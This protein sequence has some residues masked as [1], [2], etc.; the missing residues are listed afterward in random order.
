[1]SEATMP[2]LSPGTGAMP[3]VGG[4]PAI[5]TGDVIMPDNWTIPQS[6]MNDANK[7]YVPGMNFVPNG[8]QAILYLFSPQY[9]PEQVVHTYRQKPG[10]GNLRRQSGEADDRR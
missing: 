3:P 8:D 6:T 1:M 7:L 5:Q 4:A 10:C 9:L 2:S